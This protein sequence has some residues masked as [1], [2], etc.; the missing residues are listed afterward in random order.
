MQEQKIYKVEVSAKTIIFIIFFILLLVLLWIIRDLILTLFVAFIITSAVKPLVKWLEEKRVPRRLAT[1][2]VFLFFIT[3]FV[4]VLVWVVP[5]LVGET[6]LLLKHLPSMLENI[7]PSLREYINI[8]ALSQ[9][10]PDITTQAIGLIRSIFSNVMFLV[11]TLFFSAYLTIEKG[12]I[13][14]IISQLFEEKEVE[15]IMRVL[16]KTEE[17]LGAWLLGE[18][19]LMLVVGC[20]TYVG[21]SLIGIRYVLP[22]SIVAGFL[23]VVPNVGPILSTVPAFIVGVAQAPLLGISAIAL[24]FVVQQLEN[25]I[26]VPL[27][28]KK[29]IGLNPIITLIALIVGGRLFGVLGVVL[30]IPFTLFLQTVLSEALNK[31]T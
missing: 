24:Y 16:H 31:K 26:I 21:L 23:E 8:T 2:G 3:F 4:F 1:A 6:A 29:V 28:M 10:A 14:K 7:H 9:Y 22:L 27:V 19:V 25:H 30:S 5:P 17:R 15:R 18:F 11:T 13:K 20:M 12:F